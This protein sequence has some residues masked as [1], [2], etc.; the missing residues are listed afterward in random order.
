MVTPQ[1]ARARFRHY[2]RRLDLTHWDIRLRFR[3]REPHRAHCLVTRAAWDADYLEGEVFLDLARIAPRYLDGFIL[4]ELAGHPIWWPLGQAAET[5]AGRNQR[6]LRLVRR[7]EEQST[8]ML[9]RVLCRA[10][11][12]EP[13]PA[14]GVNGR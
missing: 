6:L 7:A 2:Q 1:K 9:E 13:A 5:M 12:V 14:A 4:H 3:P 11:G 10:F 8:T